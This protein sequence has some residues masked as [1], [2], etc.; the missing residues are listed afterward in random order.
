[1]GER[2]GN[3]KY[4]YETKLS[5]ARDLMD[6]GLPKAEVMERYGIV[7]ITALKRWCRD[8]RAGGPE[9]LRPKPKGRPRGAKS[10]PRPT[11]TREQLL[12]EEIAY[13][14]KVDALLVSRSATGRN[15]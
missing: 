13:L 15:R 14:E 8:Y 2:E 10:Q 9:A 7:S 6:L 3:R 11:P 12:E 4:G 5:A 1:M